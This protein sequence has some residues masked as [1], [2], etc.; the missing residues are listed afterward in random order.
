MKGM[1]AETV[2]A[3]D[4]SSR[5][6]KDLT[7]YGESLSGWWLLWKRWNPF[8]TVVKVYWDGRLPP[9]PTAGEPI[10][11]C[12]KHPDKECSKGNHFL[13]RRGG[14]IRL[15]YPPWRP[16]RTV[17]RRMLSAGRNGQVPGLGKDVV[18]SPHECIFGPQ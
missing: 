6:D 10:R 14:N 1:G 7:N 8:A 11:K 9:P 13:G 4:V 17:N 12:A 3:I 18:H 2:I 5:E 15:G 16:L